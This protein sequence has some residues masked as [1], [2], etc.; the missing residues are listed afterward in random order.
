MNEA[1]RQCGGEVALIAALNW[2]AREE[3][4]QVVAATDAPSRKGVALAAAA[5]LTS[6]RDADLAATTLI[7]LFDDRTQASAKPL[8]ALRRNFVAS[9]SGR[10]RRSLPS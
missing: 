10:M 9:R 8:P 7:Q 1:V 6:N 3:L 5:C 4:D 2:A